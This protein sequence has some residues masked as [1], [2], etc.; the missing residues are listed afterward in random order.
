MRRLWHRIAPGAA[1]SAEDGTPPTAE[2]MAA[3][4][5][6]DAPLFASMESEATLHRSLASALFAYHDRLSTRRRRR[7]NA[8]K[9][10]T[11][12][13]VLMIVDFTIANI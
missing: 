11:A 1:A 2:A 13:F 12:F 9:G 7:M 4:D 8:L 5:R 10:T 3:A 6:A